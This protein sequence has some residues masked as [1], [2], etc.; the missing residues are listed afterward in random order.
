MKKVCVSA[1]KSEKFEHCMIKAN[2]RIVITLWEKD[3][4][5]IS[6]TSNVL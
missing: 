5:V 3:G 4:N 1:L 6:G 2:F